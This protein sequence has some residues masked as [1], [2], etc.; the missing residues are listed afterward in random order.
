MYPARQCLV[1]FSLHGFDHG[2][3]S[4]A[5]ES[6]G[7]V[8]R[9]HRTARGWSLEDLAYETRGV[10]DDRG[11]SIGFIGQLERG[12]RPP[13]DRALRVLVATV[14]ELASETIW[15][16]R[17]SAARRLLDEREVG[18]DAAVA[19]LSVVEAALSGTPS[20]EEDDA[21]SRLP[22][23]PAGGPL[24]KAARSDQPSDEDRAPGRRRA[25]ARPRGNA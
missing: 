3:A 17:L 24:E 22:P 25:A 14:P 13:T 10:A 2:M 5:P 21:P 19:A 23:P 11:L 12:I 15:E 7:E 9:R 18:L 16:L 8:L 1:K 6:F 4:R 20:A